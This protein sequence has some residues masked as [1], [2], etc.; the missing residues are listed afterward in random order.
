MH[1]VVISGANRGIGL[2]FARQYAADGARVFAGARDPAAADDLKAAVKESGD[3]I[4]VH[5]LDV[6]DDRSVAAFAAAV[7]KGPVDILI[8][9]AGVG[10]GDKQHRFGALDFEAMQLTYS[11]NALGAL[12]LADA[13]VENLKARHGKFI[14][15]TSGMG[16]IGDASG[17]YFSYRASKA[18]LNMIMHVAAEELKESGVVCIPLSPGWVKTD[19]GGPN[20][21][22]EVGAA[23][24]EMRKRIAGFT[25]SNSGRFFNWE[26]R[27]LAW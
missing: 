10:G 1:T 21:R 7:G 2:E 5:A 23:V 15:I 8:A 9:N 27:E 13:L 20:A 14:A 12:R 26:G 11:V 19:M 6:G 24:R 22:L 17:G 3:R 16:S 4:S 25:I 18:A